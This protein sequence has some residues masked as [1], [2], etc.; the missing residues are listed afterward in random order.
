MT[1]QHART[2]VLLATAAACFFAVNGTVSKVVL[3][4]GVEATRLTALRC[5]GAF[6]GLA[7][8]LLATPGGRAR[9][10]L[11]LRDV[12]FLI[13]YGIVG[14]AMVQWLYFVAIERLPV[15][16][17]LLLEFTAPVFVA[18]WARFARREPVRNLLWLGLAL[19]LVGLA[20]VARVWDGASLDG[21]GV[22][23]GVAAAVALAAYFLMGERGVGSRDPLSLTCWSMFFSAVFWSVVKPWWTFDASVLTT[24]PSLLGSLSDVS[25]PTWAL[26]L[27]IVV[28]GTIVPFSF[29]MMAL[30][31]LPATTVGA[32]AMLEPVL[33]GGVAWLW[34]EEAQTGVQI[35]GSLVV[36]AGIALAQSARRG[37]KVVDIDVPLE[38]HDPE[39][40]VRARR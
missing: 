14:V 5:L 13:V 18:L 32:V 1:A 20:L 16:V 17:A 7:L 12:P 39:P 37:S 31:H 4:S 9:L 24:S 27:W 19:A 15:G 11:R 34:L 40:A 35:A 23:A 8:V 26:L 25:V 3:L 2:G 33:A 22:A 28:L 36:V 21:L 38:A 29:S 10:R 6:A 30:R